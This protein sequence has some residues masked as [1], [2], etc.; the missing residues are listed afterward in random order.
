MVAGIR[1][2]RH[3]RLVF[4]AISLDLFA[5]FLGG[6]VALLVA[7]EHPERV[8][9]LVLVDPALATTA[10][11]NAYWWKTPR[12]RGMARSIARSCPIRKSALMF[13]LDT[14]VV[15]ELRKVC[16]GKAKC[17]YEFETFYNQTS[18]LYPAMVPVAIL[19]ALGI[20]LP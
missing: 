5:V 10:T 14:N 6:A 16:P 2:I 4:G 13:I 20:V 11:K 15:S 3:E 19:F 8:A 12:R 7:L 18:Y 9:G 1:F 17:V